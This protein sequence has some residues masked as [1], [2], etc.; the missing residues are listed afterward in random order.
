MCLLRQKT[1]NACAGF[2]LNFLVL[3]YSEKLA[4]FRRDSWT[5]IPK[6]L[7][8]FTITDVLLRTSMPEACIFPKSLNK[9]G[10]IFKSINCDF[11]HAYYQID[12]T[13]LM[14]QILLNGEI[15]KVLSTY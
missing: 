5:E 2:C 8:G 12:I 10:G 7:A 3:S 1:S 15:I 6:F 14:V 11:F 9:W 13:F 4:A